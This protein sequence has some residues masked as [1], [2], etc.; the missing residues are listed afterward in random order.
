MKRWNRCKKPLLALLS[1]N[2]GAWFDE[3]YN[4]PLQ[5]CW[6]VV[7]RTVREARQ[8]ETVH[9]VRSSL[10]EPSEA[11]M[12]GWTF[13][14]KIVDRLHG[15]V[16]VLRVKRVGWWRRMWQKLWERVNLEGQ[17]EAAVWEVLTPPEEIVMH[18]RGGWECGI[19]EDCTQRWCQWSLKQKPG[20]GRSL[21]K[22]WRKTS[23]WP[24]GNANQSLGEIAETL[25]LAVWQTP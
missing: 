4:R 23:D 14:S 15:H 24:R 19:Q 25:G 21:V 17:A 11:T 6:N 1:P 13:R 7:A 2:D 9:P 10:T 16:D 20:C 5:K 12:L 18:P 22:L 8:F 3:Y